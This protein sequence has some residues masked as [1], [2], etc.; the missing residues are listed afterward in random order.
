MLI[1]KYREGLVADKNYNCA[2][3]VLNLGNQVLDYELPLSATKA[4]AGFG[5]GMGRKHICGAL[6]GAVMILSIENVETIAR[7]SKIYGIAADLL[8]RVEDR[9]GSIMCFE[10][11]EKYYNNENQCEFI[12]ETVLECLDEKL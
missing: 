7:E 1:E 12:I 9:L 2:E 10:L 11:R 8:Q 3:K 6:I 4:A 5:F